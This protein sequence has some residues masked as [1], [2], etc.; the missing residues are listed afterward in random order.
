MSNPN[1][2]NK[3]KTS[4]LILSLIILGFFYSCS[5]HQDN[6]AANESSFIPI[7]NN[8][9][10][11]GDLY[12]GD[13]YNEVVENP[14]IYVS[15]EPISTFSIDADGASYANMRRYV[16]QEHRLPPIVSCANRRIY[17]LL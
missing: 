5:Y 6:F 14:F 2:N 10:Y 16:L 11:D 17:Q 9:I 13:N 12:S 3:M 4:R 15:E 7:S 1:K 8:N